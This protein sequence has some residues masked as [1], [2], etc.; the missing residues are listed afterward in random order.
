MRTLG[1]HVKAAALVAAL[2]ITASRSRSVPASSTSVDPTS[3]I[4]LSVD[5]VSMVWPASTTSV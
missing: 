3:A 5:D 1:T 4:S 2:A